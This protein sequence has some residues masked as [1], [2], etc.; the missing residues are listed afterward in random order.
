[1]GDS[2]AIWRYDGVHWRMVASPYFPNRYYSSPSVDGY[3][4]SDALLA[5]FST[6]AHNLE[7]LHASQMLS[8]AQGWSVG[9]S[10][11]DSALHEWGP[12]VVEQYQNGAWQIIHLVPT[13]VPGQIGRPA[14]LT[15]ALSAPQES[16]IGGAWGRE[17]S[18]STGDA[19][20]SPS[21]LLTPLLLHY[22]AGLWTFVPAPTTGAIHRLVMLSA[23]EGWAASDGGLLHY[24]GGEWRL[25]AVQPTS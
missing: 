14:F 2:G 22:H 21:T 8:P 7:A 3:T 20:S 19:P 18:G 1:M 25:A 5:H 9:G 11:P 23:D 6:D 17:G 24:T 13:S 15:V 10:K 16:W 4:A 12:A